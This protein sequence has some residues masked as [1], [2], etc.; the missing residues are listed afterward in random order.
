MSR[1]LKKGPYIDPRL[2]EKIAKVKKGDRT[3]IKT[4]SRDCSITPEMVGFTFGVHNGKEHVVVL[5]TEDMVG[6]KL[7]EFSPT[8]RFQRHGGKM[9]RDL[10]AGAEQKEAAKVEA[11]GKAGAGVKAPAAKK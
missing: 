10:E 7:G 9:Q 2:M 5:I 3:I 8:T 4:W 1:S 6:H 11:A